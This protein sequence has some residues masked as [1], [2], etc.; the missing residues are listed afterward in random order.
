MKEI[1]IY[2]ENKVAEVIKGND[3]LKAM[4]VNRTYEKLV[5]WAKMNYIREQNNYYYTTDSV[6]DS[7][8]DGFMNNNYA[9]IQAAKTRLNSLFREL[10]IDYTF[11]GKNSKEIERDTDF[12]SLDDIESIAGHL[13]NPQDKFIVYA[14]FNGIQ[15][16]RFEDLINIKVE[17]V[18]FSKHIVHLKNRDI[19]MDE[20]FE[21]ITKK[22][23]FQEV[24][25]KTG[26]LRKTSE[27]Y[28]LN[29]SNK[30]VLKPK[31]T[32]KNNKGFDKFSMSG[33]KTRLNK[34]SIELE[35]TEYY[36]LTSRKLVKSGILID[37]KRIEDKTGVKWT[38]VSLENYKK[39]N[40][41]SFTVFEML[42]T[43]RQMHEE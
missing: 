26:N 42:A 36:P 18:D 40:H 16:T 29:M 9:G 13:I 10:N 37:M 22:T 32:S 6:L 8:M 17:D 35:D 19:K 39:E 33:I 34:I 25:Y 23:I 5:F 14:L 3:S 20:V 1:C 24:Y 15:G 31:P 30:Y 7:F 27:S 12:Y 28:E 2:N 43:Y 21:Q 38:N 11:K 4:D 41:L